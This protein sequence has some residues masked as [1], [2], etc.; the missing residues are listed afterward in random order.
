MRITTRTRKPLLTLLAVLITSWVYAQ[1][2][3]GDSRGRYGGGERRPSEGRPQGPVDFMRRMDENR[4]GYLERN[5]I[6]DR[7]RPF[8]ERVARQARLDMSRPLSI[9]RLEEAFRSYARSRDDTTREDRARDAG[10]PPDRGSGRQNVPDT[11]PVVPGFGQV[12]GFPPILGFGDDAESMVGVEM[13]DLETAADRLARYDTNRDGFMDRAEASRGRWSDDVF[14]YDKNGDNRLSRQ[15]LATRYAQRRINEASGQNRY[16]SSSSRSGP[17]PPSQGSQREDQRRGR[18][19]EEQRRRPSPEEREMWMLTEGMMDRYDANSNRALDPPEWH[20]LGIKSA[21][22][23][24]NND[25]RIDRAELA[26]W[27]AR[28]AAKSSQR[29]PD[30]LPEWFPR[31]DADGDGQVVMAEFADE[32]TEDKA[33]E[34]AQY[35]RNNDGVI[36]PEECISATNLP[37]GTYL[38]HQLQIIPAGATIYSQIVVPEGD[39]RPVSNLDVQISITHTRVEFLDAFLIPPEGEQVELFTGVGGQDDHF[40]NTILDDEAN[41]PIVRARPPFAGRYLPEAA[42]K[43]Q[44]SLK[45]FYGRKISGTWTLMIRAQR[46]DRPGALHGWSLI[47]EYEGDAQRRSEWEGDRRDWAGGQ[48]DWE[49]RFRER[50][51]RPDDRGGDPRYGGYRPGG[52]GFGRPDS[53]RRP[54]FFP[55]RR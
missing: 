20:D 53:P 41:W 4:N 49:D 10:S 48:R 5:E 21:T 6:S 7:A 11:L 38:N 36:V 40:S 46:S 32:W 30:G 23:D 26:G 51:Y 33:D 44:P 1:G 16:S 28:R 24:A 42:V 12:E 50:G 55:P 45:Q 2:Y 13:A 14:Q 52:G 35:D 27:L 43:G 15:E 18:Q 19:Q 37:E 29:L 39:D 9:R 54:P 22:A 31:C 47:A 8:L 17:S 25:G 3:S 34:F